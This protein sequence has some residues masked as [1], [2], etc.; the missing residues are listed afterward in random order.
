ME[1]PKCL[2]AARSSFL[3]GDDRVRSLPRADPPPPAVPGHLCKGQKSNT[4][5]GK[6][7]YR[8]FPK[9]MEGITQTVTVVGSIVE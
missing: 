1:Y 8:K 5:E 3:A 2:P 7:K 9:K 6:S 4:V